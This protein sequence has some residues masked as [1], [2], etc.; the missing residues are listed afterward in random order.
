MDSSASQEGQ[1]VGME[2]GNTTCVSMCSVERI[3]LPPPSATLRWCGEVQQTLNSERE[4]ER[5]REGSF[6]RQEHQIQTVP[7]F[8]D[9]RP[10]LPC[11]H[12][13]G[14]AG[15]LHPPV[16]AASHHRLD[17]CPSP[18]APTHTDTHTHTPTDHLHP[19]GQTH[20]GTHVCVCLLLWERARLRTFIAG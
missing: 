10:L 17:V 18:V 20:T 15:H 13:G 16:C 19:C 5:E 2:L 6:P 9:G 1:M 3:P 8:P 11:Q 7:T 4:R 14:H 12:C